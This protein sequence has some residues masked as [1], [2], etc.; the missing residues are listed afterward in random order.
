MRP[1]PKMPWGP[2]FVPGAEI[3]AAYAAGD[4]LPDDLLLTDGVPA[5]VPAVAGII[6][7]TPST[8]NSHVAILSRSQGVPFVHLALESD[9]A[10]AR[11]LV[12]HSVYLAVTQERFSQAYESGCS[13]WFPVRREKSSLRLKP[14][15]VIR[16]MT[17]PGG[18]GQIQTTCVPPISTLSARPRTRRPASRLTT[19]PSPQAFHSICGM[20]SGS[21]LPAAMRESDAA[22]GCSAA[23]KYPA[24]RPP[25]CRLSSTIEGDP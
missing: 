25:T 10:Q 2:Q 22:D 16:P 19:T 15:L 8:P 24:Y 12:G 18:S 23:G 9:A 4:L 17:S 11:A 20:V 3:Q 13:M 6:S 7:L 5:E 21:A 14:P 1:I